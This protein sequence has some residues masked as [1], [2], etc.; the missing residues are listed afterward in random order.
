MTTLV[1]LLLVGL[2]SVAY[3]VLPLL[4]AARLPEPVTTAATWAGVSVL[5]AVAARGVLNHEDAST[6]WPTAVAVVSVGLGLL[7]AARGRSVLLVLV[8]GATTYLV[9]SWALGLAGRA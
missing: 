6:P 8:T 5:V 1:A 2:G 9:L 3:R 7:V 4:G